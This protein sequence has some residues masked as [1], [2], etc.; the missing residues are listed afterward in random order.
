MKQTI[1]TVHFNTPELTECM[2]LSIRKHGCYWP[3]VV[4]D[5]SDKLPF[6]K[7]MPGVTVIDNTKGQYVDFD[8]ELAKFPDRNPAFCSGEAKWPSAKHMMSIQ[9]LFDLIPDGFIL[10]ESD[11]LVNTNISFLWEEQY[12]AV[13]G[14]QHITRQAPRLLP[15]LCYL[16]V[17]LLVKHGA[18]YFDDKRT[19]GLLADKDD[20]RNWYDTGAVL[21]ED[22][23][24][25][26]PYLVGKLYSKISNYYE[27]YRHGSW[28]GQENVTPHRWL[29]QHRDLW[30]M[31]RTEIESEK[32]AVCAM[33]RMENRYAVE[34][35]KHYQSLGFDKVF[36]Y[37]NNRPDEQKFEEVLDKFVK[38]GYVEIIP[39]PHFGQTHDAAFNDCYAKHGTEYQWFA[40][41]DFDEFLALPK[42]R[43]IYEY[44][45]QYEYADAVLVNWQVMTDGG[46]VTDDG[47]DCAK[48]FK[49]PIPDD[50]KRTEGHIINEY[51]KSLVRGGIGN[52]KFIGNP[53]CPGSPQLKCVN[54]K[55]EPVRQYPLTPVVDSEMRLI[56]YIT[57]YITHTKNGSNRNSNFSSIHHRP[58]HKGR[59]CSGELV[60][61]GFLAAAK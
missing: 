40:Y 2:I 19:F 56:H 58:L 23:V 12:A 45:R 27:H 51:V 33:G 38:S 24:N 42:G 32:T 41:V 55:N 13:G 54:A 39:W 46:L 53:H 59:W 7:K 11:I 52:L 35:V 17:P 50:L 15:M 44:M 4:F 49:T 60:G 30:E 28:R 48:R 6:T 36:I 29:R 3:V 25:T 5:N 18:K 34:F 16:N 14:R 21:L 9:K 10:A 57:Q 47:R 26:K 31:P 43:K 37:D 61:F 22:I 20:P 8:A 1:A